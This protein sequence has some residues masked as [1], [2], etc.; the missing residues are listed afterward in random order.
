[1]GDGGGV[2]VV[3]L[4]GWVGPVALVGVGGG[5]LVGAI[6]GWV[7]LGAMVGDGVGVLIAVL[8]ERIGLG[9]IM[10]VGVTGVAT[11]PGASSVAPEVGSGEESQAASASGTSVARASVDMRRKLN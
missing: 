8:V 4:D 11:V 3:A 6:S 1:M 7:A 2:L 5:L 10:G 9:G